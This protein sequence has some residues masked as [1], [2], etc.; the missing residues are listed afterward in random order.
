MAPLRSHRRTLPSAPKYVK[1]EDLAEVVSV[2][3]EGHGL[4]NQAGPR[5][6]SPQHEL[7]V[8]ET[9]LSDN[10]QAVDGSKQGKDERGIESSADG[11]R[12]VFPEEGADALVV[13]LR[14]IDLFEDVPVAV[15]KLTAFNGIAQS[16]VLSI[17][18]MK[19]ELDV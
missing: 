8:R 12:L 4:G 19:I 2:N 3:A 14:L 17:R 9:F 15:E 16:K 18:T 1:F 7:P 13:V 6:L 5:E 11:G 10:A